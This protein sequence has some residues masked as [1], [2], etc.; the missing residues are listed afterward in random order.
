MAITNGGRWV[1]SLAPLSRFS[2]VILGVNDG[3]SAISPAPQDGALNIEVFTNPTV[4]GPGTPSTDAGFQQSIVDANGAFDG[5]FLT[6]ANLRLGGGDYLVVDSMIGSATQGPAQITLGSGNQTVVG[7]R[8]DTL[9]GGQQA[10]TA[11]QILSAL[12]GNETVIGG[13]ISNES[14]W[15]GTN[16]SIVAG[17]GTQQIVVTGSGTTVVAGTGGSATIVAAAQ[18]T[19]AALGGDQKVVVAAGPNSLIDLTGNTGALNAVIGAPG[20]TI[21]GSGSANNVTTNIEAA[22]GG[23]RIKLGGATFAIS[24]GAIPLVFGTTNVSGS[25]GSS[26]NTIIGGFGGIFN[27]NPSSVAGHGDLI[28]LSGSPVAARINAFSFG[29]TRIVSPDTILAGVGAPFFG[30]LRP[31]DTL[32]WGGDGDRIGTGSGTA[33]GGAHQWVHADTVAGSAVSFGSNNTVASTTYD[34]VSGVATRGT[35]PGTSFAVVTVGGFN[36]S[37]DFLFYQNESAATNSAIVAT[38][39]A[40]TVDGADSS[41]V[42]LPD[43]TVMTLVGVTQVELSAAL[44]ASTLFRP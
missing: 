11:S 32:V 19:I 23:M 35:V 26:G 44:A 5:A 10:V 42:T 13:A 34:T 28:D 22:G 15:G 40:A 1:F 27:F 7:A 36:T 8:F 37:T 39:R 12:A 14:I 24:P 2:R 4:T 38:A 25:T 17:S 6:G 9:I 3:I 29:S 18:N 16:D 31:L 20:D 21:I 43:G 30:G 41:I 33:V